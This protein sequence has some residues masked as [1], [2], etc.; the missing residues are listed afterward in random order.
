MRGIST[1]KAIPFPAWLQFGLVLG[2]LGA[3]VLAVFLAIAGYFHFL[4]NNQVFPGVRVGG[5]PLGGMTKSD[6][7][8]VLAARWDQESTIRVSDGVRSWT[9]NPLD[10]GLDVN[11]LATA[12]TA[13]AIGRS[14]D[15]LASLVQA[16]RAGFSGEEVAP[17]VELDVESAERGLTALAEQV[18]VAPIPPSLSF[19]GGRTT[20]DPGWPGAR[21][22]VPA[23]LRSLAETQREILMGE[24]LV[25]RMQV[26]PAES[27]QWELLERLAN[28]MASGPLVLTAY[29]PVRD[30][31]FEWNLNLEEMAPHLAF[32]S[33]EKGQ[34]LSLD[35]DWL[36]QRLDAMS[37]SLGP[38]QFLDPGEASSALSRA[39]SENER[40]VLRV[41]HAPTTYR[42]QPGDSLL[43]ISWDTGIPFWMI[44]E[45]NPGLNPDLL[46]QGMELTIPSRDTLLPLP[47]IPGKRIRIDIGEQRLWTFQDGVVRSEHVISTGLDRSPTQP[48]VFQVRTHEPLAYASLWDLHMPNFLGIYEA[49]PGFMNGIHGLPTLSSGTRLWANVLGR[50]ASYGCIILDLPDAESLYAW[51]EEGVVVE[52]TR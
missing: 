9:M 24:P 39:L 13:F 47:V 10:I 1:R 27:D 38:G 36:R 6:A 29:D 12:E 21:L 31:V 7:V 19:E 28:R 5:V 23:T 3:I 49:W 16:V 22:D 35:V 4:F 33:S 15:L 51:A 20:I 50:P 46:R 26:E 48:G 40:A 11:E 44:L 42:V 8:A 43:E 30:E 18:S 52:I 45:A 32:V 34:A 17:V 2:L 41:W 25:L 14:G 37:Q